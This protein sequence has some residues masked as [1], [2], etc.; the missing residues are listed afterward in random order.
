M[1]P[2]AGIVPEISVVV[3]TRDRVE[4]LPAAV[5]SI[6]AQD[7]VDLELLVVDDASTDATPAYLSDIAASD[8]RVRTLGTDRPQG[9]SAARNL[10]ASAARGSLLAFNDDDCVWEVDKLKVQRARMRSS[11]AGVVYCREAIRWPELGWVVNGRP[12]AERRGAVRS[13]VTAN[14]IGTVGPLMERSVFLE[15]G[16]FDE[17]LPRL[18]EW[19]LWLRMGLVTGFAFVDRVLVRGEAGPAG[20]SASSE[21]LTRAA[22]IMLDKWSREP[23]IST[24]DLALLHYGMGKYLLADGS[25]AAAR[26]AFRKGLRLDP[27]SPLSWVGLCGSLLTPRQFNTLKRGR[28]FMRRV[29]S[30]W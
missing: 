26:R 15:A 21:S 23:R 14:Y 8:A 17:R 29:L 28:I 22:D 12:D 13:L 20:I 3:P 11:G 6:L 19:D 2:L 7:G 5:E 1:R 10:G 18:Q 4:S 27:T 16:G 30:G 24:R 9:A 25:V